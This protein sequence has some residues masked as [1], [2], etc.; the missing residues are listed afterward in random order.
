MAVKCDDLV[1]HQRLS[2]EWLSFIIPWKG[3]ARGAEI[4]ERHPEGM[5]CK[6][7]PVTNRLKV[8]YN[9]SCINTLLVSCTIRI[10]T[11]LQ[12]IAPSL[13]NA[14]DSPS[15]SSGTSLI[16]PMRSKALQKQMQLFLPSIRILSLQTGLPLDLR[17]V[18]HYEVTIKKHITF[19]GIQ[20]K[21]VAAIASLLLKMLLPWQSLSS[22]P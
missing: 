17:L 3:F 16:P 9:P 5:Y 21:L 22:I 4:Q 14:A 6:T 11:H 10:N 12:G 2:S 20:R 1:I 15:P 8:F 13:T 18:L 7:L 19:S